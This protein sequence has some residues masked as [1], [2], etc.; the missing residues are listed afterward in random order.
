MAQFNTPQTNQKEI[1][2]GFEDNNDSDIP[3][4]M[5]KADLVAVVAAEANRR[6][7][8]SQKL[9]TAKKSWQGDL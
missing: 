3:D 4:N 2:Y 1:A 5:L 9:S 8:K 7:E 6:R